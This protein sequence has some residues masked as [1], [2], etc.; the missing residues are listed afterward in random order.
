MK[1]KAAQW[2]LWAVTMAIFTVMTLSGHWRLVGVWQ[3]SPWP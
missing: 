1:S 2:I 3:S